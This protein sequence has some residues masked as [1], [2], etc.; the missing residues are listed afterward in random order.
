MLLN[1]GHMII[2]KNGRACT[3]GARGCFEAY[4]SMRCFKNMA[5]SELGIDFITGEDLYKII[6]EG[7]A[8]KSVEEFLQNLCV[9]LINIINIFEPEAICIG[10]SFAYFEDLL[11][12][13]LKYKLNH[14]NIFNLNVPELVIAKKG[15]E[16]GMIGA[17]II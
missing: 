14:Q 15:N 3:C 7:K 9:G 1:Y 10:G 13:R 6:K 16:A 4:A 8:Q 2:K 17:T 11:L 12:E 5:R